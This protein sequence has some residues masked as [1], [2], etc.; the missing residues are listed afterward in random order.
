MIHWLSLALQRLE[1]TLVVILLTAMTLIT[2]AYVALTNLYDL[3]YGLADLFP[4]VAGLLFVSG[5]YLLTVAQ[6]M[7][8]S[9]AATKACFAWFIF[10]G[11]AYAVRVNAHIGVDLLTRT[12]PPRLRRGVAA[13]AIALFGLYAAVLVYASTEWVW[14]LAQVN[15]GAEDLHPF[16]IKVWHVALS[17]PV[18][19]ALVLL[20]LIEAFIQTWRGAPEPDARA[21]N[22]PAIDT[23]DAPHLNTRGRST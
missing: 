10:L 3:C 4:A 17:A 13:T 19:M 22:A 16:G 18:G 8:W 20:R 7:T 1:E 11:A 6:S 9:V 15:I 12:L 2:F 5:D 23:P 14:L 21:D